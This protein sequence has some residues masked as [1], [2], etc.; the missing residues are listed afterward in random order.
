MLIVVV[1][2]NKLFNK[3]ELLKCR[4]VKKNKIHFIWNVLQ[5]FHDE[6][7]AWSYGQREMV[8]PLGTHVLNRNISAAAFAIDK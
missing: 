2:K 6:S 4:N 7:Y 1:T 8:A 3:K 5:N